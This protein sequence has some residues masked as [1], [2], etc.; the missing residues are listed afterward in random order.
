MKEQLKEI[1]KNVFYNPNNFKVLSR[2]IIAFFLIV[3]IFS[4]L[5]TI[6]GEIIEVIHGVIP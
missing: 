6:F 3:I 4:L 2:S 5:I 1:Y